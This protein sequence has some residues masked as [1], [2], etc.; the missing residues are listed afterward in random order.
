MESKKKKTKGG[1]DENEAES[2]QKKLKC[3]SNKT[4]IVLAHAAASFCMFFI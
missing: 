3:T 4:A 1:N 2:K